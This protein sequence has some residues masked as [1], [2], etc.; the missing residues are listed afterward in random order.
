MT[1]QYSSPRKCLPARTLRPQT[2]LIVLARQAL[3]L[4]QHT[5]NRNSHARSNEASPLTA[6]VRVWSCRSGAARLVVMAATVTVNDLLDGHVILDVQCLDRIYLNGY[7]PNL[8]VGGQ[9]VTFMTK[10][11]GYRI[12][13]PAIMEKIGTQFRQDVTSFAEDHH[14]PVVRFKKGDR[15]I[16]VMRGYLDSQAGTGVSG[17]AAIGVAQEYQLFRPRNN[18]Y[19]SDSR[20][21]PMPALSCA[22]EARDLG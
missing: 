10:H 1:N 3:S 17:V 13:S 5:P 7:V 18:W 12:P 11:L 22:S 16:D 15:K 9:V 20:V 14:I 8:Q 4:S 6:E 19:Y 21:I 2:S